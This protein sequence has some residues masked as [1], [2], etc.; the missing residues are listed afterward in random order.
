MARV[1]SLSALRR[2]QRLA[3][4]FARPTSASAVFSAPDLSRA[5]P[6]PGSANAI[7]RHAVAAEDGGED[8]LGVLELTLL[9]RRE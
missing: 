9:R 1:Q 2:E 4:S 3:A 6:R 7:E 5:L 8:I